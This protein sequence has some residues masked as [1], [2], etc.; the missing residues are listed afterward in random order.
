V[1]EH[2]LSVVVAAWP[3]TAGLAECLGALA[4]QQDAATEIVVVAAQ[5]PPAELAGRFPRVRW[6]A[7]GP[8]RLIPHLWGLGVARSRGQVVAFTT[9]HFT[10]AP[11]W[12]AAV[13]QAH[14]RL[15]A[16]AIGGPIEP[17]RGGSAVDWA[18]FFLRYSSYLRC[19]REQDVPDLAGD[20][21]SYKRAVLASC[22]NLGTEGFWELDLHRRLRAEGQSL[23][24][25]P[26]MR[27]TL[28]RS[29][30]FG[31]FLRQRL[32]HGRHFGRSRFRGRSAWVRAVAVAASPLVP[33]VFLGKITGRVLRSRRDF[34]PFLR[35]LPPLLCFVLAW[36]LGEAW[37][38]LFPQRRQSAVALRAGEV[39]P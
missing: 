17:P 38:Y 39:L 13:R 5:E 20:N 36:S 37:G 18:T 29:F 19:D 2:I 9:A 3:D 12:V 14:V 34:G 35:A 6:L 31:P 23:V 22:P 32:Q 30:G 24:F 7:A 8:D 11:G 4:P 15:E 1:S 16:P 10:P 21:A 28:R 33:A 27:V 25:V 26:A